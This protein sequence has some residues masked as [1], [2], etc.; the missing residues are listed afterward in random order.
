MRA[1]GANNTTQHIQDLSLCGLFFMEV[2]K[3][4]DQE[5]GA[6]RSTTHTTPEAY[7][8]ISII[9]EHLLHKEVMERAGEKENSS[10]H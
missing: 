6:H 4:I 1:G 9:V 2:T 7:R 8:D 5:F 3:K 10:I